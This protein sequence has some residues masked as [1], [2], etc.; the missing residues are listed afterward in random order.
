[1]SERPEKGVTQTFTGPVAYVAGHDVNVTEHHHE[2]L[3]IERVDGDLVIERTRP[4]MR[5]DDPDIV[6]CPFGC[7]E[8]TWWNSDECW[9]CRR[10]VYAHFRYINRK[11]RQKKLYNRSGIFFFSGLGLMFIDVY[12][13][14][15]T[16]AMLTLAWVFFLLL[17][18]ICSKAAD[19]M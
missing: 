1:V 15:N 8:L 4:N 10:P 19:G 13:P 14:I 18:Y 17:S 11:Q 6:L 9:N 16:H 7:G 5:A 3:E 2:H 12:L